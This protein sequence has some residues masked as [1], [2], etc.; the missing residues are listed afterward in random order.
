MSSFRLLLAASLVVALPAVAGAQERFV[1]GPYVDRLVLG[2]ATVHVRTATPVPVHVEFT[3]G[4]TTGTRDSSASTIHRIVLSGLSTDARVRYTVSA[5]GHVAESGSFHTAPT[6]S[7]SPIRFVAMGDC[8]DGDAAHA[9][10]VG[11]VRGDPDFL[12]HLG[13]YV[14]SGASNDEWV[15][16]FRAAGPL[17]RRTAIV[18]T[19]GNHE[20]IAP[21]GRALYDAHFAIPSAGDAAYYVFDYDGVRVLVLDSNAPLDPGTRQHAFAVRELERAGADG[22]LRAFFVAIHH[23]PLSSGRHGELEALH[24]SGLVDAMR[25]ARVDLVFSGHD[26]IYE[27]GDSDGLKYI[28][29]GG[30]GSPL[31]RANSRAPYQLEFAAAFHFV[32]VVVDANGITIDTR[33]ADGS[34]LERCSFGRGASFRCA[35]EPPAPHEAGVSVSE[36]FVAHNGLRLLVGVAL[37][38]VVFVVGRRIRRV[39]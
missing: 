23:G 1:E 29:T 4:T 21:G 39:A 36:D 16:F 34:S 19:L 14:P 20:I 11:A 3:D 28:V 31:Y 7:A 9:R 38:V 10:V 13:D 32:D 22:S 37:A 15:Q 33:R 18:P 6:G 8:R 25:R 26:H 27:R 30:C 24:T 5:P 2:T 35:T 12:L 17:L